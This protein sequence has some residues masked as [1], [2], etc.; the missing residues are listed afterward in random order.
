ML[1]LR[2]LFRLD[3]SKI[4]LLKTDRAETAPRK[5]DT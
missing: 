2:E 5:K 1:A 3:G 4:H